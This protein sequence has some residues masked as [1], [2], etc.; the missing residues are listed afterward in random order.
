MSLLSYSE[1]DEE[2]FS[3]ELCILDGEVGLFVGGNFKLCDWF[4]DST[5][6]PVFWSK[7][8]NT[9]TLRFLN[10]EAKGGTG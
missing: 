7:A 1:I 8:P 9:L 3:D 5:F 10:F 4:S 2:E 6:S